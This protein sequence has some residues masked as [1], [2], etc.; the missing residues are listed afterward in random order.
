MVNKNWG[1]PWKV[2]IMDVTKRCCESQACFMGN[3]SMAPLTFSSTLK[4]L[5]SLCFQDAFLGSLLCLPPRQS[6]VSSRPQS[7]PCFSSL[8]VL[9]TDISRRCLLPAEGLWAI[10]T[11]SWTHLC[12]MWTV[13][14][15]GIRAGV[16]IPRPLLGPGIHMDQ[17]VWLFRRYLRLQ[18]T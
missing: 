10:Q 2:K 4:L 14:R 3:F 12:P 6:R 18:R 8:S 17:A 7:L 9:S 1:L 16:Q 13:G 5:S 15:G 11:H